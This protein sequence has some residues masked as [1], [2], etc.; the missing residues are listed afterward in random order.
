MAGL[1]AR[2]SISLGAFSDALR[3]AR[4][5][6]LRTIHRQAGEITTSNGDKGVGIVKYHY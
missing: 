3:D 2:K 1:E 6:R 5:P 4:S